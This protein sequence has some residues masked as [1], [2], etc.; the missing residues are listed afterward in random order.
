[1]LA[2]IIESKDR[3]TAGHCNR[4]MEYACAIGERLGL[5]EAEMENLR[6][7]A[8]LH[9]V[10]K[11]VI[12]SSVLN[13]PG[14]LSREEMD[15]MRRHPALGHRWLQR[16][17]G[18]RAVSELVA[19]HHECWDGSGYP[20]GLAGEA[21]P[22]GGRI[23]AVADVWDALTTDRPYRAALS[24]EAA[25]QIIERGKGT[26]FDARIAATFLAYL[27]ETVA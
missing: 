24:T 3:Y 16:Q 18:L 5:P 26:Q 22:L 20:N 4:V 17:P 11:A 1:M 10:G 13:K 27:D 7:G 25:R 2:E 8:L 21:I 9:D 12:D 6:Y 19:T 15:E 23:L 14:K